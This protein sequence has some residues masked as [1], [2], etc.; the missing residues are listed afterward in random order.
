MAKVTKN[1]ILEGLSGRV[2]NLVFRQYGNQ[3]VVSKL[4]THDPKRVPT[5]DEAAQQ[6]RIKE[7]AARAKTVLATEA[8]RAYY[9]AAWQRLGKRSAYHTAIHDYFGVPEVLA[10]RWQEGRLYIQVR[11]NVGVPVVRVQVGSES[12]EAESMEAAPCGLWRYALAGE[13]PR[14]MRVEAEDGMGNV[15]VWEGEVGEKD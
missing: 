15:G 12:G 10:V 5:P 2:G 1:A 7:A 6:A 9:E 14:V 3:T 4:P 11:N 13:V 8:G